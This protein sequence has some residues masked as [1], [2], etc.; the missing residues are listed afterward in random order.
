MAQLLR[1]DEHLLEVTRPRDH[2]QGFQ[3]CSSV[4]H[5]ISYQ[6]CGTESIAL[7]GLDYRL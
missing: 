4:R 3:A 1:D 2:S 6:C 7:A 5:T